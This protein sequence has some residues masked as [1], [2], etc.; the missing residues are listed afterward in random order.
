MWAVLCKTKTIPLSPNA[1]FVTGDRS[2]TAAAPRIR[3]GFP[4]YI[5]KKN[6]FDEIK[7]LIK[8]HYFKE[9]HSYLSLAIVGFYFLLLC[10]LFTSYLLWFMLN[11]LLER[12][13]NNWLS[14]SIKSM[15]Y[16]FC[17]S[18]IRVLCAFDH[19]FNVKMRHKRIEYEEPN[20]LQAI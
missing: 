19:I 10:S 6:D 18:L 20:F 13:C 11:Y 14:F 7:R 16:V 15:Y 1:L 12:K 9:A 5:R 17:F 8:T 2:F 3:K 4:E